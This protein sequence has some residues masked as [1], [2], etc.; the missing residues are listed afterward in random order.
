MHVYERLNRN[1]QSLKLQVKAH[2]EQEPCESRAGAGQVERLQYFRSI[3]A[4]RYEK[5]PFIHAFAQ[6]E[7]A[8]SKR[9]LE[10]GLGSG[11]D[12]LQWV[13]HG[14]SA[15]GRDLTE[16]SVQLVKER[17]SVEGLSGDVAVGDVEA[18]EFADQSFD[19]VY[20]YGVIHHTP[21]TEKAVREIYRVLKVGGVARVMIYHL[22]GL[23]TL[24]Q[25]LLFGP[26][27]LRP[28]RGV[29]DVVFHHNE[30]I[31]TKLYSR[32]EA[33][34]LFRQFA[35]VRIK[36]VIDAGDTIDF[37]L[38]DRYRGSFLVRTAHRQLRFL[39]YL[40]PYLPAFAGTTMLIE[41]VK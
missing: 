32:G 5:S 16:A 28:L 26:L 22:Y 12:F 6:F 38:S 25:W 10:I 14:A 37:L 4:Y 40:R 27:Q 19:L 2:W 31:G 18:L 20:S 8:R 1:R 9:V 35:D 36:T 17:L 15:V 24:Y 29:R 23:S 33:K 13:R 30:S 7:R 3:D 41:A 39:R 11:S 34:T 21:D